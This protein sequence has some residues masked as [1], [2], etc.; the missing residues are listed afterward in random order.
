MAQMSI[1]YELSLALSEGIAD[2]YYA[3]IINHL[4]KN[5]NNEPYLDQD[6]KVFIE[7]MIN[8]QK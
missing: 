7:Q 8:N 2:D 4:Q 1:I 3:N 5:R 6:L